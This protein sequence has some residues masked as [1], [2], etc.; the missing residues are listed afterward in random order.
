VFIAHTGCN[1]L[2]VIDHDSS[3]YL[4][5][6]HD[7]PEAAG[8][9][10]DEGQVLVT[11]RAASSLAL[12][13]GNTLETRAVF[14]TGHRPNGVAIVSRRQLAVV[15]CIGDETHGAKLQALSFDGDYHGSIDLPG[16][17]RWCVTDTAG[18]RVFLAI[19]EPSMVLTALLPKLD[20]VHH[21]T[22]PSAGAHGLDIDRQ[23]NLLYVA[24]DGGSLVEMDALTGRVVHEWP[25]LGV[26]DA[27]FFNPSSG[28]VHVAIG[29]PGLVQTINPRTGTV[30]EIKTGPGAKTTALVAPEHL[31]VFSP[32]HRG[33]LVLAES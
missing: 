23:R 15:A 14:K 10:A 4:S 22:L 7:F 28:L 29:D 26:P 5:T 17:P 13:D 12:V 24:C 11:S 27:T 16:R 9:V 6:L 19:R 18:Q 32:L 25:L 20:T 30:A 3:R 8:V 31:Y 33:A 21:W 2:E 1:S